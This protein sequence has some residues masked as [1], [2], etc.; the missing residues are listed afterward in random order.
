[1]TTIVYDHK[2]KQIACDSR[3]TASGA[4]V[5]D[6]ALKFYKEGMKV[7]FLCGSKS[8]TSS[9]ISTFEHNEDAP[10]NVRCS[11]LV[12][13]DGIVYKACNEDGVYK[14]DEI[15]SNEGLGSGGWPAL[16][17]VDLG[18]TAKEAV[19]YA[20][21]RDCYSGGKV[22]VYDIEKGEFL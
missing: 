11:G 8:D 22:H 2:N 9:F 3:E 19:E 18:K 17:A 5:T 14:L 4:I 20:M 13:I 21:T 16:A 12:V 1:M 7:W 6:E 15:P 10:K